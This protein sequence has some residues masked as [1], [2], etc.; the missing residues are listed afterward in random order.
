MS[1]TN[2]KRAK[3]EMMEAGTEILEKTKE[4]ALAVGAMAGH[5]VSAVGE[6]A[7]DLTAAAGHKVKAAGETIEKKS[8]HEGL[9]G[10]ASQAVAGAIQGTGQYIEKAKLSGM[11][12]DLT[13]L[14]KNHP[15]PT[16]LICFG[17]GYC[18][19]HAMKE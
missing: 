12:H 7:D 10:H 5:A 2:T 15:V 16:M 11:A 19:G 18:I 6:T 17:I 1:S 4:A 13:T 14:A 9:T 8:P 3:D